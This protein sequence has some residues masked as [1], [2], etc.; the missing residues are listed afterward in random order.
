MPW[1]TLSISL[2]YNTGIIPMFDSCPDGIAWFKAK[3]LWQD[4]GYTPVAGDLIFYDWAGD[5]V[6][7]HV[8]IVAYVEGG[9]VHTIEGNTSDSDGHT[10]DTCSRRI[11][12]INSMVMGYG[13]PI[14]P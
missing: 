4:S 8:G 12:S 5:G 9:Y 14:Y 6:S 13:V 7:D 1:L 11:R 10:N 2:D 3:G